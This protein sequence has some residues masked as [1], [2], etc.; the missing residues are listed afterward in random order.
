MLK[1]LKKWNY[2][3]KNKILITLLLWGITS[4]E[5]IIGSQNP[6]QTTE[7]SQGSES[8]FQQFSKWASK[9]L[10]AIEGSAKAKAAS[11]G[12]TTFGIRAIKNPPLTAK[13]LTLSG[14]TGLGVTMGLYGLFDYTQALLNNDPVGALKGALQQGAGILTI[15]NSV[16]TAGNPIS[17]ATFI[18]LAKGVSGLIL[19]SLGANAMHQ[20]FPSAPTE[21]ENPEKPTEK[22]TAEDRTNKI[23]S[24]NKFIKTLETVIRKMIT[25]HIKSIDLNEENK[26]CEKILSD[27]INR[28]P[29]ENPTPFYHLCKEILEYKK[30]NLTRLSKKSAEKWIYSHPV[31]TQTSQN[32]KENIVAKI[33]QLTSEDREIIST[34]IDRNPTEDFSFFEDIID[35]RIAISKPFFINNINTVLDICKDAYPIKREDKQYITYGF[36]NDITTVETIPLCFESVYESIRR[37]PEEQNSF[38]TMQ[39]IEVA[40]RNFHKNSIFGIICNQIFDN[41]KITISRNRKPF[42]EKEA[43]NW[44]NSTINFSFPIS[45]TAKNNLALKIMHLNDENRNKIKNSYQPRKDFSNPTDH[46]RFSILE[47]EIDELLDINSKSIIRAVEICKNT[48][49]IKDEDKQY[50][51]QDLFVK[52]RTLSDLV[53]CFE[54]AYKAAQAKNSLIT[55]EDVELATLL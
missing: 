10:S 28:N 53:D 26:L 51:T 14:L 30:I 5:V 19:L 52:I 29:K 34:F 31:L 45:T 18:N 43:K 22:E 7:A 55:A 4:S 41:E 25:K 8:Y 24:T 23:M 9:K 12:L 17:E 44:I 32:E 38:I 42:S 16:A 49:P 3:N 20:V 15:M 33:M 36:F 48:Y 47:E 39:E 1:H 37:I 6:I 27:I 2:M 54:A 46:S 50:I 11:L 35:K 13:S 40:S 21:K